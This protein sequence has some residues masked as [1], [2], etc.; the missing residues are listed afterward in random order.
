MI[1]VVVNK[2]FVEI[3]II[4]FLK[5]VFLRKCSKKLNK[6]VSN[7]VG[8]VFNRIK[9]LLLWLIFSKIKFLS[10]FVLIKVVSVVVLMINIIVV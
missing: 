8:I 2:I 7:V 1:I 4:V 10:L 9:L 3:V 5:D 6:I